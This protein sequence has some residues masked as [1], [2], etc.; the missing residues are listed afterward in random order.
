VDDGPDHVR[1]G[2]E[3]ANAVVVRVGDEEIAGRVAR[4]ILRLTEVGIARVPAVSGMTTA[5]AL[6][7]TEA[8]NRD[9]QT[10]TLTIHPPA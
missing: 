9:A 1:Q 4:D 8:R 6:T 3:T 5:W 7:R 2:V 10:S